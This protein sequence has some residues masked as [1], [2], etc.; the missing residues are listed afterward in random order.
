MNRT[1]LIVIVVTLL[2]AASC[3]CI[4]GSL[5]ALTYI[6]IRS[7]SGEDGSFQI[8]ASATQTPYVIRP[9]SQKTPIVSATP[10]ESSQV[11]ETLEAHIETLNTLEEAQIPINDPIGLAQRLDGRSNLSTTTDVLPTPLEVGAK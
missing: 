3:V 11:V 7:S 6:T 4:A 1:L 5:G 9:T 8:I 10:G 2:L